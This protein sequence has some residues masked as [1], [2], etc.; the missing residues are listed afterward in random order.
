[1]WSLDVQM[2]SQ[3]IYFFFENGYLAI[4]FCELFSLTTIF[5]DQIFKVVCFRSLNKKF[6]KKFYE[7][8]KKAKANMVVL[9]RKVDFI[10]VQT[11]ILF[12]LLIINCCYG[13]FRSRI[14][15][16]IIKNLSHSSIWTHL[17]VCTNDRKREKMTRKLEKN[18]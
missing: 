16:N 2:Y 11:H 18:E 7:S 13:Y 3:G 14:F 1:M 9:V 12:I 8:R 6:R 15:H 4:H 17:F 5:F 10:Y